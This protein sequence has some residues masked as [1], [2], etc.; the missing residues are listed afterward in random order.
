MR[1]FILISLVTGLF[2]L[3]LS[4]YQYAHFHDGKLHIVF[5][6]VGQG[7]AIFVKTP[8]GRTMLFDGGP[9]DAVL[10]CLDNHVPFWHRRIDMLLLSHPHLDHFAGFIEVVEKYD[11]RTFVT[12]KLVNETEIF[13]ELLEGVQAAKI[14]TEYVYAGNHVKLMDGVS[15]KILGPTAGFL[16]ET[17][18]NGVIGE[19]KEFASL[20]VLIGYKN[21]TLLLTGDSQVSGLK[22]ALAVGSGKISVLQVPHH[23]S[24]SGL[25]QEIIDRIKPK[26]AVI[27]VGKDNRYGHPRQEIL[28]ILRDNDIKILRTDEDGEVEIISD[29]KIF[30]LRTQE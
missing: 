27:S 3:C 9:D 15:V 5:C 8:S 16:N 1:K 29:G 19:K 20:I 2:L 6:D 17:S 21:F 11:V 24:A 12:E 22:D 30:T 10:N 13:K 25:D 4:I 14:K 28:K 26:L 18:P 7:D 23:G